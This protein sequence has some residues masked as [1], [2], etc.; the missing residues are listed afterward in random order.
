M[1]GEARLAE[2][3][4]RRLRC[5]RMCSG[6]EPVLR[7]S[8]LDEALEAEDLDQRQM[9]LILQAAV[10]LSLGGEMHQALVDGAKVCLRY[11]RHHVHRVGTNITIKWGNFVGFVCVCVWHFWARNLAP[12]PSVIVPFAASYYWDTR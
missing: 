2:E 11:C 3:L 4:D 6:G 9:V 5:W 8:V 7:Q 10:E 1:D 12:V